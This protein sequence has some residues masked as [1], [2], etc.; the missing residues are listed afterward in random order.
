MPPYPI[1][2]RTVFPEVFPSC[3]NIQSLNEIFR[4]TYICFA[5]TKLDGRTAKNIGYIQTKKER[6]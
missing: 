6:F 4:M 5:A 2:Y 1:G 3:N